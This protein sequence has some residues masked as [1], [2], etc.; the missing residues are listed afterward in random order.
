MTTV[1]SIDIYRYIC[2]ICQREQH[3]LCKITSSY[4]SGTR[5]SETSMP[6]HRS[7]KFE[8]SPTYQTMKLYNHLPDSV[9]ILDTNMFTK[10]IKCMML[11][12]AYYSLREFLE[13]NSL[14]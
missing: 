10:T 12:K 13:D 7:R 9:K 11:A 14:L 4:D 8:T 6:T 1:H 3:T 2:A 5:S